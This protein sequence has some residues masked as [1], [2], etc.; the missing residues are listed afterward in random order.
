M[1]YTA[2]RPEYGKTHVFY[3]TNCPEHRKLACS[4]R[5]LAQNMEKHASA[6]RRIAQNTEKQCILQDESPRTHWQLA[7]TRCTATGGWPADGAEPLAPGRQRVQS[8]WR[9]ASRGC[10]ATPLA[11][12]RQ[13]VQEPL[14]AGMQRV[15][16]HYS[17]WLAE[18]RN[19][20]RKTKKELLML[21]NCNDVCPNTSSL[22]K[23]FCG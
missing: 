11:P 9:L 1:F 19:A 14:A 8:H 12:G 6:I 2:D 16:S 10:G 3:K 13:R 21:G 17:S 20:V 22:K 4:I 15:E 18:C 7:S 23:S 5:R